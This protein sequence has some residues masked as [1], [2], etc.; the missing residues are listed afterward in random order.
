MY[1]IDASVVISGV[2]VPEVFENVVQ[3]G[4]VAVQVL[5]AA[6]CIALC[7]V[8]RT[9]ACPLL[10]AAELAEEP[11]AYLVIDEAD[12]LVFGD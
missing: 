7:K 11:C 2:V 4:A 3:V 6:W 9:P 12:L 10:V 8:V 1:L 5:V